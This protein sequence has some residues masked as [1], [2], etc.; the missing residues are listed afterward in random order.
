MCFLVFIVLS[1]LSEN[2]SLLKM[3]PWSNPW[4]VGAICLSM[5]LHFLILYVDPLPVRNEA[6]TLINH[7]NKPLGGVKVDRP[8]PS[9]VNVVPYWCIPH[10]RFVHWIPM[11]SCVCVFRWYSR[12]ALCRGLSGWWY[13]R[14]HFLSSWWMRSSNSWPET[15]LSQEANSR[16]EKMLDNASVKM[17]QDCF[18]EWSVSNPFLCSN[19]LL[20]QSLEEEEE[21]QRTRASTGFFSGM[22]TKLRQSL[23]GVSWSFV[24]ISAP[25]VIWIFSLDSDIT[26]IFWEWWEKGT[27]G[28]RGKQCKTGDWKRMEKS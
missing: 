11:I 23:K 3:P 21:L 17:Q 22:V 10:I 1:S 6:C 24:L 4:L 26:N 13:W 9:G 15:I 16:S 2:Q 28:L 25:L 5:A 20:K 8:P 12:Y 19:P 14:C 27:G 7:N 18:L